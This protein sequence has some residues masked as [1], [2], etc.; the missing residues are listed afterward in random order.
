M[1][2]VLLYYCYCF[3]E[4]YDNLPDQSKYCYNLHFYYLERYKDVFDHIELLL[5][6]DDAVNNTNILTYYKQKFNNIFG[7]EKLSIT[8]IENNSELRDA[9]AYKNFFVKK[10]ETYKDDLLF[11][12]QTKGL[13]NITIDSKPIINIY[14]WIS[15][16]Y[17]F[18]LE[19]FKDKIE[20]ELLNN[21]ITYGTLYI[22]IHNCNSAILNDY[23]RFSQTKWLYSGSFQWINVNALINYI[24]S[25]SINLDRLAIMQRYFS[26]DFLGH[27]VPDK[28]CGGGKTLKFYDDYTEIDNHLKDLYSKDEYLEFYNFFN[29]SIEKII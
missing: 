26:E 10:L 5:A 28:L 29:N 4:P 22:K 25:H 27:I 12:S 11:F 23:Y 18:N 7:I 24:N 19:H 9:V 16:M 21:Y 13:S 14:E 20:P 17:Y 2:K 8:V 3:A 15:A 6:I 1:R